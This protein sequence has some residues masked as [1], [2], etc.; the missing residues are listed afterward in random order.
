MSETQIPDSTHDTFI[1]DTKDFILQKLK[2][3]ELE[4]FKKEI[5]SEILM[6]KCTVE[7][8]NKYRVEI[9][10]LKSQFNDDKK[11]EV[12]RFQKELDYQKSKLRQKHMK[13]ATDE[14]EDNIFEESEEEKP[15]AK[16]KRGRPKKQ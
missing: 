13:E 3:E 8:Y 11:T 15:K 4:E 1:D 6:R 9:E 12:A 14:I 10:K 7:R 2:I 16:G 5:E